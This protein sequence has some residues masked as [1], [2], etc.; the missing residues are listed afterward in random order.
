[1][2]SPTSPSSIGIG[3]QPIEAEIVGGSL[4]SWIKSHQ[5]FIQAFLVWAILCLPGNIFTFILYHQVNSVSTHNNSTELMGLV[6]LIKLMYTLQ[7][8]QWTLVTMDLFV[9]G[10]PCNLQIS[11]NIVLIPFD[12]TNWQLFKYFYK[13]I[14]NFT[15]CPVDF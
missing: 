13:K 2:R 12:N 6:S 9:T 10:I 5:V 15:A 11:R 8:I 7:T 14:S 3:V 4:M 1:M